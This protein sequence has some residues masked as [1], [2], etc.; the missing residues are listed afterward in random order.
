MAAG[1][2][3]VPE[4]TG[5][6]LGLEVFEDLGV[7]GEALAGRLAEELGEEGVGGD[8]ALVDE[9]LDLWPVSSGTF[10][11]LGLFRTSSRVF[12][13]LSLTRSVTAIG[14]L[15]EAES[16]AILESSE[17]VSRMFPRL[18]QMMRDACTGSNYRRHI[19]SELNEGRL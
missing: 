4:T 10:G 19:S 6:G 16:A 3:E 9:G 2:E 17:W 15:A 12:F 18:G 7:G 5:A 13:A 14:I 11:M 1:E 8:A